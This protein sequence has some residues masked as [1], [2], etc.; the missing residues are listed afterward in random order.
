ML[1]RLLN[2]L[3]VSVAALLYLLWV[4]NGVT[5]VQ[6]YVESVSLYEADEQLEL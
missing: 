4:L 6:V 1:C 3:E 2:F 5:R